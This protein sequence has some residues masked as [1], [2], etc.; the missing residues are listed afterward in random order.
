MSES[1]QFSSPS[2]DARGKNVFISYSVSDI[3]LVSKLEL[4]LQQAGNVVWDDRTLR[5]G[6]DWVE[7]IDQA[8][9]RCDVAVIV[10]TSNYLASSANNYEAGFL[11]NKARQEGLKVIPVVTGSVDDSS[12]P[13]RLQQSQIVDG[14]HKTQSELVE[15]LL[16]AL[17]NALTA[18]PERRRTNG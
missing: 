10:V 11:L 17:R 1:R 4:A 6:E 2:E 3:D 18:S 8:I 12:I 7:E 13:L 14:R 15:H 16:S 9:E 5:P